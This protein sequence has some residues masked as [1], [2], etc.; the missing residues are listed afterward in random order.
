MGE[1]VNMI[2]IDSTKL[3][4]TLIQKAGVILYLSVLNF[5]VH[6]DKFKF[7]VSSQLENK[8]LTNIL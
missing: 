6:A 3:I 4:K 8:P 2:K 7:H 5:S 1:G